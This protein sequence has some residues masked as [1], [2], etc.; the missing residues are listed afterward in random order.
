MD[1]FVVGGYVGYS[2]HGFGIMAF[3]GEFNW[4]T[5]ERTRGFIYI[6]YNRYSGNARK[7]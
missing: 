2:R 5:R 6:I 4:I 1:R 3:K 7:K